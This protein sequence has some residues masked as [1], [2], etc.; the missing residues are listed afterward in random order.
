MYYIHR[1]LW[2]FCAEFQFIK[3]FSD[4]KMYSLV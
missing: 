2:M 4:A 3:V 1:R